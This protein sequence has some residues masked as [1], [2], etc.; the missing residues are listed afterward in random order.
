[1]M[2]KKIKTWFPKT[3]FEAQSVLTDAEK[4]DFDYF[5]QNSVFSKKDNTRR[6][7]MLNVDSSHTVNNFVNA[8]EVSIFKSKI[9]S[10]VKEYAQEI[11]YSQNQTDRLGFLNMWANVSAMGDYNFPHNHSGSQFSG[12]YYLSSTPTCDITFYDTLEKTLEEPEI[13]N[14]LSYRYVRY[15]CVENS[16][17]IFQ[18]D[19]VHGNEY[20]Q[21]G[22]KIAVS[23]NTG[24]FYENR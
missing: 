16:V 17:L 22:R 6:N 11:G 23:F 4:R 12:V 1:M 15:E 8:P 7:R 3:I 10:L 2:N 14:N 21:E 24:F 13:Y 18:S 5:L 19:L 20:Q 9:L